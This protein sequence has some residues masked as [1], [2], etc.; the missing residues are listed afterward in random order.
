MLR[1]FGLDIARYIFDKAWAGTRLAVASLERAAAIRTLLQPMRFLAVDL[2]GLGTVRASIAGFST[3]FLFPLFLVRLDGFY[4]VGRNH[5][6]ELK[7]M[8]LFPSLASRFRAKKMSLLLR[9]RLK[10]FSRVLSL[11]PPGAS[12]L[13]SAARGWFDGL[14]RFVLLPHLTNF[15][16][17]VEVT[18][19]VIY[20][21]ITCLYLKKR[22]KSTVFTSYGWPDIL[23]W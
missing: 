21:Y 12:F 20:F 5:S 4:F 1:H 7:G 8:V 23:K 16:G 2:V 19:G 9:P 6:R 10:A 3:R 18:V 13:H 22:V 14:Y 15:W 17:P 11:C